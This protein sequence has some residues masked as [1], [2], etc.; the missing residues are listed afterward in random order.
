MCENQNAECQRP[1]K[2]IKLLEILSRNEIYVTR[3][4]PNQ[5]V[6]IRLTNSD[7]E[8]DKISNNKTK[9]QLNKNQYFLQIPAELKA[10]RSVLIFNVDPYVYNRSE[11]EMIEEILIQNTWINKIDQIHKF[12]NTKSNEDNLFPIRDRKEN[13]RKRTFGAC[14]EDTWTPDTAWNI[15]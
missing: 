2:D 13:N 6:F 3:I 11:E 4:I 12:P 14:Y 15:L 9:K 10:K 5:D 1:G 7:N 8:L